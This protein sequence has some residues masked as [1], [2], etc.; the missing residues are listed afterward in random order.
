MPRSRLT[1]DFILNTNMG[2]TPMI[3]YYDPPLR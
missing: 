2:E 1:S 3:P